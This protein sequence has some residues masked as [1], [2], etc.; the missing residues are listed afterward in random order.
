MDRHFLLACLSQLGLGDGVLR[1]VSLLLHDTRAVV[2]IGGYS[3]QPALWEAG[4]RQ[5]CPLSPVLFL[6]VAEAL[7]CWLRACPHLGVVVGGR[8]LVA[9]LF[10]DDTAVLLPDLSPTSSAA[11]LQCLQRYRQASGQAVNVDKSAALLL[12]VAAAQQ[13]AAAPGEGAAPAAPAAAPA[14]AAQ[15]PA[16]APGEEAAPAAPAAALP[17]PLQRLPLPLPLQRS[18][19]QQPLGRG[20]PLQRPRLLLPLL[21]CRLGG[22]FLPLPFGPSTTRFGPLA[23]PRLSPSPL[24]LPLPSPLLPPFPLPPLSPPPALPPPLPGL[25]LRPPPPSPCAALLATWGCPSP[26]PA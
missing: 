7:A 19:R 18:S 2:S 16:A 22:A 15:Q 8:R 11:L 9:S 21:G 23:W 20:L 25:P 1:W 3:S 6:C 24:P 4:V 17:L 26:P 10:A 14:P 13:L 12:G 5:G